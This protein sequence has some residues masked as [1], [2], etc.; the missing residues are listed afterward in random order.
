MDIIENHRQIARLDTLKQIL[1]I[2]NINEVE[3]NLSAQIKLLELRKEN[4]LSPEV[5]SSNSKL[6]KP[7]EEMES[8]IKSKSGNPYK[9]VPLEYSIPSDIDQFLK[10]SGARYQ[11]QKEDY[12][13]TNFDLRIY[14]GTYYP[15]SYVETRHVLQTLLN[16]KIVYESLCAK[17]TI[18]ILDIGAGSGACTLSILDT[19]N[20]DGLLSNKHIKIT[21]YDRSK[22]SLS[23][24]EK[25]LDRF[26]KKP[27]NSCSLIE[28][29]FGTDHFGDSYKNILRGCK[30]DIIICS[31]FLSEMAAKLHINEIHLLYKCFIQNSSSALAEKGLLIMIDIGNAVNLNGS[32]IWYP[33]IINSSINDIIKSGSADLL[34]ILP[35]PC[36]KWY[37]Q[38]TQDCYKSIKFRVSSVNFKGNIC[39][40][41]ITFSVL[42]KRNFSENVIRSSKFFSKEAFMKSHSIWKNDFIC[43]KAQLFGN[44]FENA[45]G[46]AFLID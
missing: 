4:K 18:S 41:I 1:G 14:L 40:E 43:S 32:M 23:F 44:N 10:N 39:D 36:A 11:L 27:N 34:Y 9:N 16:N 38:C 25:T 7:I 24:F 35:L 28:H 17:D 3:N 15:R 31:K 2:S 30:F 33:K 46:D 8:E 5:L 29:N 45:S 19:F 22:E 21:A 42:A 37:R 13:E 26:H 20:R 6:R 12:L